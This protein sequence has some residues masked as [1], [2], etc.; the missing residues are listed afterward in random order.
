MQ[1]CTFES[2]ADDIECR[3]TAVAAVAAAAAAAV[4]ACVQGLAMFGCLWGL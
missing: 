3:P 2:I 1:N 4:A